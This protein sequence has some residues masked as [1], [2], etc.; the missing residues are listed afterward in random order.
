MAIKTHTFNG[1]KYE[2]DFQSC[3]GYCEEPHPKIPTLFIDWH[4][5]S[6][7]ES[8]RV[9]IHEA[10]HAC[11]WSRGEVEVDKTSRDITGFLWRLGFRPTEDL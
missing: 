8:L 1:T 4:N 2:I 9:A 7:K 3:L 10:L 6:D 11:N 5:L